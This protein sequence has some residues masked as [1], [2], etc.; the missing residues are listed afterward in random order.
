MDAFIQNIEAQLE[1]LKENNTKLQNGNKSA[2]TRARN[3]AMQI[4]K[5]CKDYRKAVTDFKNTL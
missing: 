1:V 4:T 5:D 2:G 3:A